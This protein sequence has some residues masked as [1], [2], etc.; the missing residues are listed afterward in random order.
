[1]RNL[2]RIMSVLLAVSMLLVCAGL[3]AYAEDYSLTV[4]A[5]A[6]TVDANGTVSV[7]VTAP[8]GLK[9]A[10]FDLIFNADAFTVTDG[11]ITTL[12]TGYADTNIVGN[13]VKFAF[14]DSA[15]LASDSVVLTVVFTAKTLSEDTAAE[16][17]L[18]NAKVVDA[19]SETTPASNTVSVTVNKSEGPVIPT[20]NVIVNTTRTNAY[21]I[22]GAR[23]VTIE[24]PENFD[25][26]NYTVYV[27]GTEAV[28]SAERG[29]FI[30]MPVVEGD[31]ASYV[32]NVTVVAGAPTKPVSITLV[33]LGY[34]ENA[35]KPNMA[36]MQNLYKKFIARTDTS[37]DVQ[38][39]AADADG[40]AVINMA[41]M[42]A[43]YMYI[44]KNDIPPALQVAEE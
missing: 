1:M 10:S 35:T 9:G 41:D 21:G 44:S 40:N 43:I 3:T 7:T 32:P 16:F 39:I 12:D 33:R 22:T 38:R 19:A 20:E 6:E 28:Y 13:A 24:I 27:D 11:D 26:S 36:D 31:V 2:K 42:Q 17:S 15:A 23:K 37:T 30:A 25:V 18:A 8:A 34:S 5:S 14:A 4:A 29:E